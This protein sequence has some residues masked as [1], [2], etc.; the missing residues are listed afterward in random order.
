M[1]NEHL[2]KY[3]L[4]RLNYVKVFA[5][6]YALKNTLI[7]SMFN[8]DKKYLLKELFIISA[9]G[10]CCFKINKYIIWPWVVGLG[11]FILTTLIF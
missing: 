2:S 8:R 1:K 5:K 10:I 11:L 9:I 3:T 4:Q 7:G 6:A